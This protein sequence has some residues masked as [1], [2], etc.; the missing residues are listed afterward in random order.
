MYIYIYPIDIPISHLSLT[1]THSHKD[2]E[3]REG[4]LPELGVPARPWRDIRKI[5]PLKSLMVYYTWIKPGNCG[6]A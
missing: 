1:K 5:I 6:I 4:F 2:C 3:P